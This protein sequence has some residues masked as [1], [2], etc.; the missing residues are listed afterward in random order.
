MRSRVPGSVHGTTLRS[1]ATDIGTIRLRVPPHEAPIANT[2]IAD[3]AASRSASAPG[4]RTMLNTLEEPAKS[5][6]QV[7]WPGQDGRH[8]CS[9]RDTTGTAVSRRANSSD[10]RP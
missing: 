4:L 1:A 6:F 3:R 2:L 5:L 8:G 7:S 10:Q 9:T